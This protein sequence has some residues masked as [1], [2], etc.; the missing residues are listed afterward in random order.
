MEQTARLSK[1]FTLVEALVALLLLAVL[2][3]GLLAGLLTAMRYNIINH[4]RDGA[5]NLALEC[6]E[7]LRSGTFTGIAAGSVNCA[8]PNPVVVSSPCMDIGARI[9]DARPEEVKRKIRNMNVAYKVGWDVTTSGDIHRV[10]IIVCWTHAGK[11]YTY[12]AT[13]LLSGENLASGGP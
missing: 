13:T 3:L 1:G 12:S 2:L 5:R 11:G 4:L 10:R 6:A 8:D 7:N 9:S